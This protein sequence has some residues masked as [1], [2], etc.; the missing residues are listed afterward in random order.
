MNDVDL[1]RRFLQSNAFA[2]AGASNDR[3]KYGNR[4]F[5]ALVEFV[6]DDDAR[7]V[8]PLNPKSNQ[9]EGV[10]AFAAISDAP[11]V[12]QALSIV[13]PPAITRQ[14]V[15][16]AIEA[17]INQIWMQ[18]GAEDDAAIELAQQAGCEVIAGGPCILVAL[19][20]LV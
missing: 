11:I 9:I 7:T 6:G 18:P 3:S 13:T 10:A 8:I 15:Q 12:P 17:G 20:T 4:V 14:V 1:Q 5:R 19:R 2:V 16:E